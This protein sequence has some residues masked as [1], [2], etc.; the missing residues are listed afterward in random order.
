MITIPTHR[1]SNTMYK[2]GIVL[3]IISLLWVITSLFSQGYGFLY[4]LGSVSFLS[5]IGSCC[6]MVIGNKEV[7][8]PDYLIIFLRDF[9]KHN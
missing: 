1:F 9:N 3:T 8:D 7:I 5:L 4:G 6:I 2:S